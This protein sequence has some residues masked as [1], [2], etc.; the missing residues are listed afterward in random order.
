[1]IGPA[2]A[3]RREREMA[4]GLFDNLGGLVQ[5]ALGQ[6]G[7]GEQA[8]GAMGIVSSLLQ[9]GGGEGQSSNIVGALLGGATQGGGQGGM[10]G[11]LETLAANGLADHV[12]SWLGGGQNLPVSPQQIHDALGSEQVQQMAN[13][14]GL[15]VGDFLQHLADHLPQAASEASGTA[16]GGGNSGG[17]DY[18]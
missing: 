4:V 15:P 6:Q 5:G 8:Q 16:D 10:A 11:M 2:H 1:M 12:G 14:S 3:M 9:Q 13:A 17:D 18:S 7:E